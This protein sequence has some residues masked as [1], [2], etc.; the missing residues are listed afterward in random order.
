[1]V[2]LE[3]YSLRDDLAYSDR[4]LWVKKESDGTVSVGFSDMAQKLMGKIMFVR[5]PKPG[6][7][8]AVDK[9]FG[10]AESMKWVERLKSPI[11]GVVKESNTVLRTK[12]KIVNEDPYGA[13]LIKITPTEKLESEMSQLAQGENLENFLKEQIKDKVK[14]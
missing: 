8:V 7:E 11:S 10:T 5:L 3:G 1:M 14:K 2:E 6:T 9:D 4:L 12:P 13:W